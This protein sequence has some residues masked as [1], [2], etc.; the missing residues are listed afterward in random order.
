MGRKNEVLLLRSVFLFARRDVPAQL[1]K[2][3]RLGESSLEELSEFSCCLELRNRLKFF[4]CRGKRDRET[5]NCSRPEF[6]VLRLEVQIMYRS[7]EVLWSKF[8]LDKSLLDDNFR[9]TI[10]EFTAPPGLYLF[11]HWL[12][13]AA[14]DQHRNI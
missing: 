9:R 8:A 13:S 7:G 2:L 6:L 1:H 4:E 3:E 5:P 14:F 10:R 11:S 12:S